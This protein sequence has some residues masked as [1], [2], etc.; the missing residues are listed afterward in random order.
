MEA[1]AVTFPCRNVGRRKIRKGIEGY[2][3]ECWQARKQYHKAKQKYNKYK[4]RD[5]HDDRV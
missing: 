5:N 2:S 1:A 4:T 3:K